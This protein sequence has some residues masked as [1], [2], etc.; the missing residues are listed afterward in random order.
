MVESPAPRAFVL[1]VSDR[2]HAGQRPDASGPQLVTRLTQLGFVVVGTE[3]VP[4]G[5]ESVG[6]A[7]RR[8]AGPEVGLLVST[9]GTGLTP[10]DLTPEATRRVGER[11]VP[12]LME[13][14]RRRCTEVVPVAALGR[15]V[16]VTLGSTL[17]VNLPGNPRAA[18][19]TLDAMSDVLAHAV[20]TL[21]KPAADCDVT[22]TGT[23]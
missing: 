15:G 22:G 11:E 4:D 14:A 12:G 7:L 19:E 17:I 21:T 3:V 2:T 8:I 16:A 9:G 18:L 13:L 5:I 20:S 23:P 10:R 6:S 1:T